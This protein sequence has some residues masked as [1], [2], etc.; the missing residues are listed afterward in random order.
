MSEDTRANVLRMLKQS[1][2]P[3]TLGMITR[4]LNAG[5]RSMEPTYSEGEIAALLEQIIRDMPK[6]VCKKDDKYG[7]H[8]ILKTT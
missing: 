3:L 4:R 7:V 2:E 6:E 1:R 8:R 5:V